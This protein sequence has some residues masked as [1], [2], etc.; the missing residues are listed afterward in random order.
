MDNSIKKLE[1]MKLLDYVFQ[2]IN[3]QNRLKSLICLFVLNRA[4]HVVPLFRLCS[5]ANNNISS[6]LIKL[7]IFNRY[8]RLSERYNLFLLPGTDIGYGLVF[9]HNFPVVINPESIIGNNV[10]IH[11]CVLIGR[12]RGKK[13]APIIGN[14]VFIGHGAKII[15]NP[16]IGSNVFIAPGAIITKDVLDGSLVGAG[17][18]NVINM[19]GK[20][21]VAMYSISEY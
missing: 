15:G 7:I 2:D 8:N 17:I 3:P 9:P 19:D 4:S 6:N 18:N 12:D 16:I 5:W 21:H 14:N 1:I 20:R 11:P 13:G 10:I